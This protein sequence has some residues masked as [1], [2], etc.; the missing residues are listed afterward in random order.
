MR[1]LEPL[2]ARGLPQEIVERHRIERASTHFNGTPRRNLHAHSSQPVVEVTGLGLFSLPIIKN[3]RDFLSPAGFGHHPEADSLPISPELDDTAA[4]H[5]GVVD[6]S[7]E[8]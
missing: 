2:G 5:C 4:R 3:L 6:A 8:S 1:R 7:Q